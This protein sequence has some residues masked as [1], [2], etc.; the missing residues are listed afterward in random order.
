MKSHVAKFKYG[1]LHGVERELHGNPLT[2]R[3]L[4]Y[5]GISREEQRRG[6]LP[7][8]PVQTEVVE[9]EPTDKFEGT[10]LIYEMKNPETVP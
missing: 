1:P 6:L 7:L 5:V 3:A 10:A 8:M 4:Q 2:Y 9:Y